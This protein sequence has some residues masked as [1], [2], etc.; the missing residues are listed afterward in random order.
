MNKY[1]F[2]TLIDRRGTGA[3]KWEMMYAAKPDVGRDIVP[4]SVAD[5]EFAIAPEIRTAL[6]EYASRQIPGYSVAPDGF[7]ES[8]C[9]FLKRRHGLD[10]SPEELVQTPGI[11]Y[12]L[13]RA[14]R[15]LCQR[16]EGVII[17]TPVYYPFYR[18]IRSA[19]CVVVPCPLR[20]ENG[21]YSI[22]FALLERLA[23]VENNTAL[24]LCSPHNPVGRVWTEAEIRR[25]AEICET[26]GL[27]VVSD[28]IHFDLIFPGHRHFSFAELTGPLAER[29]IVCTAPSKTF[30]LAGMNLS[31]LIIRNAE[32][33][34]RFI[35]LLRKDATPTLDPFGY[36][37]CK[38]AY[39]DSEG[40]LD[41][42][43]A[44]LDGNRRYV[45][46]YIAA[47]IPQLHA[48]PLEGTYL[49]WIDCRALGL[50]KEALE[51]LMVSH[52]LFLD[53]GY[54]FGEEGAGFERINLACPRSVLEGAMARLK[55]AVDSLQ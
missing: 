30:N 17:M 25:I 5:M 39:D 28:E 8:V 36:V 15:A 3:E 29:T 35:H 45:A 42:L 14:I 44:Y 22:D 47:Q 11:V 49:Q 12:A 53:E 4:L 31:N 54:L 7:Y 52:D 24:L 1:N 34:K 50:D 6:C 23:A 18:V 2:D 33:R 41:A 9:A 46:D 43:L 21:C 16:G 38:A 20:C 27:A 19:G 32:L 13:L 55:A 10:V 48:V 51:K 40:W 26:H 37:A